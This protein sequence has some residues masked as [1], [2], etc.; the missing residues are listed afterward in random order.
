LLLLNPDN[1]K[2]K[3]QSKWN[4]LRAN[5]WS[6]N[7]IKMLLDKNFEELM[8]NKVIQLDNARWGE[9]TDLYQE[10]IYIHSWMTDQFNLLDVYFNKL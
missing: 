1:F 6:S 7:H 10:R 8:K 9:K 2:N 4:N 3:L 5:A